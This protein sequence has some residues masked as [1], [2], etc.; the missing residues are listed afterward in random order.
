ML[1]V[2]IGE[3]NGPLNARLE[4]GKVAR[5]AAGFSPRSPAVCKFT[6]VHRF[7]WWEASP[8]VSVVAA[9]VLGHVSPG[10]AGAC[11]RQASGEDSHPTCLLGLVPGPCGTWPDRGLRRPLCACRHT[12]GFGPCISWSSCACSRRSRQR[13]PQMVSSRSVRGCEIATGAAA[14]SA[15]PRA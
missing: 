4:Q 13:R 6:T 3:E 12:M 2:G 10:S 8:Q 7:W 9:G 1:R 5:L 15:E 11:G 14:A